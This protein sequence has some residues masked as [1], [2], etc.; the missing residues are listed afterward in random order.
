[1]RFSDFFIRRPVF[2]IVLS[3]LITLAGLVAA[4]R[5]PISEF[6]AIVP[7]TVTV[8]AN[9]PGAS[10]QEIADTVA[11]PIEQELNGV[12]G[13]L[14]LSSQSI[15]DG[16]LTINVVFKP[17]V[18]V[19]QAQSLVQNR[20]AIA[21][22]R[23][24]D[25]V[26]RLGLSVKKTSPDLLLVL[27][28]DSPNGTRDQQYISNYI[29]TRVRDRLARIEGVGDIN[30]RGARDFSMR[31]W[32]DPARVASLGLT[33]P[34]VIAAV[35]QANSQVAAG[36]LNQPPVDGDGAFQVQVQAQSRL[37]DVAEFE[38]IVVASHPDGGLVR[39]RDVARV[40]MGAQDYT[41]SGFVD[42][43][44]AV[45]LSITQLPGSN[46][47]A[48]SKQIMA[49]MERMKAEFPED[50]VYHSYYNPSEFIRNSIDKVRDTIFE[51][52]LLVSLAM[53]V[54]LG[55]WRAAIIPILAIPV[56]LVGSF[57]VLSALGYSLNTLSLFGLVLAIGIV[58]DDAIVVVENVERHMETG[59]S[60]LQ[61]AQRSMSE[62]GFALIAIALVLVAVFVPTAF[63]DGISG[64]FY[65]Q[66]A[67]TIAA[68]TLISALVSLTLS[69][70]LAALLLKP[71]HGSRSLGARWMVV[72]DRVFSRLTGRYVR[73]TTLTLSR[74]WLMLPVYLGLLALTVWRLDITPTGFV[75]QLDRGY[76]IVSV[77]LPPGSTLA[78]TTEVARD[79]S[80]RLMSHPGVAHTAAFVGTDGATFTSAPN[81]AVIFTM[82]KDFG[83]R[84]SVDLDGPAMLA[85]LRGKLAPISEARVMVIPP[86]SVPGIGTGGG[87][88]LQVRDTSDQGAQALQKVVRGLVEEANKLPSVAN[89]F[90]PFN[91]MTPQIK[92]DLDRT[93]AEYLGVPL[94]RAN[95]TLQSYMAPVFVNDMNLMGRVWRVTA[96]AD[97]PY[98]QGI[99]DLAA[100]KTRAVSGAMVPLGSL[101]SFT[102]ETAPFR[103]PRYNLYPSAEIQGATKPG[104]STGQTIASMEKLLKERLPAGFDYEWTELALQEKQAGG[105]TAGVL[106]LSVLCVYLLLAALFESWLLPLSVVLIVPACVLAAL[107]GVSWRSMDNNVL[108]QI[109]IVVLIGLAAKNAI[110]IVEFARQSMAAGADR[111]DA[112]I[113]AARTRLR[114]ILMTSLAFLLGALPLMLSTGPGAEMRQSMG[115][116]VFAGMVGVTLSG[117]LFTPLLFTILA[118]RSAPALLAAPVEGESA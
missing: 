58:V 104:F 12:D 27:L 66:F 36:V 78:R 5:L 6:P 19:D 7:P 45:A 42:N 34:E 88:K 2:A 60:P 3:V 47:L 24:P 80:A 96:Q 69:P 67:V 91:A 43:R 62:V 118:R 59:M 49:E 35:R 13:M 40:E 110:L 54:F 105:S 1:M 65:R 57:T 21:E 111:R 50:L 53:L 4:G 81:A 44:T 95:E 37:R 101:A 115:T 29:S 41:E 99:E 94:S 32:L 31:I 25:A 76:A 11:A 8:K 82:F 93:K 38:A 108:T 68:S 74:R 114:P 56:S 77:Q 30:S 55:S 52:A 23:L 14:Y 70:A 63:I 73:L 106:A 71:R 83:E 85:A 116:A 20:V 98:R 22:S 26:R 112:A 92:V 75:P 90:T 97:A 86:P 72:F 10:A 87:F 46:A 48:T 15:G 89:A 28:L 18:D 9:Y 79:A 100:L 103:V 17:G 16:K 113:A 117:L 39:L 51:A 84:A 61:A 33:A 64:M 102:Q 107:L 109:S